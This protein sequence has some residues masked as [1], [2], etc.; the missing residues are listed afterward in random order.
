[1]PDK[2][3]FQSKL[4][5]QRKVKIVFWLEANSQPHR[6]ML[7]F[8]IS[9]RPVQNLPVV[10]IED[11]CNLMQQMSYI[12]YFIFIRFIL[13]FIFC[14][15]F[16]HHHHHHHHHHC[17]YY[18]Y[19][20]YYYNYYY[21]YYYYYYFYYSIL[22]TDLYGTESFIAVWYEW[23]ALQLHSPIWIICYSF[24]IQQNTALSCT[25]VWKLKRWGKKPEKTNHRGE[26]THSRSESWR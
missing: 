20:Y 15:L 11:G 9:A 3:E 25:H 1:M 24:S 16:Y 13:L 12:F 6:Y 7:V 17:Y 21:Y 10:W 4:K 2:C 18:Y 14:F 23:H 22:L 5:M 26:V 19:Y 8:M